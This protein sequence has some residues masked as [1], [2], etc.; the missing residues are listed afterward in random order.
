MTQQQPAPEGPPATYEIRLRGIPPESLLQRFPAIAV[1]TTGAQ[2]VLFRNVDGTHE[3]DKLLEEL[4]AV[5]LVLSEL[6]MDTSALSGS[7][8]AS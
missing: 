7:R 3:L 8:R 5:G 4:M 1:R 2:T 6:H